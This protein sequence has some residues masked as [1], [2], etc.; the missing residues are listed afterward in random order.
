MN[1]QDEHQ[2]AMD[3]PAY[4][5]FPEPQTIPSGWDTSGFFASQPASTEEPDESAESASD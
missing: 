5:P 2:N 4:N 3:N 1:T